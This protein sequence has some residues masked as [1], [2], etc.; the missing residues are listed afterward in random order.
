MKTA[1]FPLWGAGGGSWKPK[2]FGFFRSNKRDWTFKLSPQGTDCHLCVTPP[3]GYRSACEL[4]WD[5]LVAVEWGE[6]VD[7]QK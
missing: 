2:G 3:S 7:I 5:I 6:V 1:I 4:K